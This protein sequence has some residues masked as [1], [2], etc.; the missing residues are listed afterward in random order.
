MSKVYTWE[1]IRNHVRACRSRIQT[2][3]SLR[4]LSTVKDFCFDADHR[5]LYFLGDNQNQQGYTSRD[6]K[7]YEVDLNDVQLEDIKYFYP[8]V[9][10]DVGSS[11]SFTSTADAYIARCASFP[12]A[13]WSP[14]FTQ[15]AISG[16]DPENTSIDPVLPSSKHRI[17]GI[18]RFQLVHDRVLFTFADNIYVAD[19]GQ[20]PVLIPERHP[21]FPSSSSITNSTESQALHLLRKSTKKDPKLGG[22]NNDLVAFIRDRDLWV[23]DFEGHEMQLTF[24]SSNPAM[25]CGLAEYIMQ[26]EFCRSTGYYWGSSTA[27]GFERLLYLETSEEA[28]EQVILKSPLALESETQPVRYPRPGQANAVS[29]LRIVEFRMGSNT[30]QAEIKHKQL[31]N[32][33]IRNMFPWAEYIVRF[34]WLSGGESVWVQILSRDQKQTALVKIRYSYFAS[35]EEYKKRDAPSD[36]QDQPGPEILWQETSDTWINVTDAYY[37]LP[38]ASEDMTKF[39]WASEKSGFRHLYLV[40]KRLECSEA[41]VLQL[42]R[43]DWCVLDKELFVDERRQLVYFMAKKDTCTEAHLYVISFD[44]TCSYRSIHRLTELGFSHQI[45]LNT[46]MDIF[47]DCF[48]SLHH[49][50]VIAIRRLNHDTPDHLPIV[51]EGMTVLLTKIP[52]SSSDQSKSES[53]F[54]PA[55]KFQVAAIPKSLSYDGSEQG[56]GEVQEMT[57]LPQA[58][59]FHYSTSDGVTLYGYLFKP[60]H[61]QAGMT[62]PTVLHVYGGPKSQLVMNDFKYP[63]LLRY[64]LSACFGF[65]VVVIDGRGSWD[66]GMAFESYVKHKLGMVEVQDQLDG[67]RHVHDMKLG[68]E[69]TEDGDVV[70]VVDLSRIAI[71][72]WS[73]GG[74]LSLMGLAQHPDAFRIAIAGAPVTQW[75]LYDSAY[76][77]RYMGLPSENAEAYKRSN[78]LNWV[79][80]FP[81]RYKG[82]CKKTISC[83]TET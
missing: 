47:V 17:P 6:L 32:R 77:E 19:L 12:I 66:R 55:P 72:G 16:Q 35:E 70:S 13:P 34:G 1:Q 81:D 48:S 56:K 52:P 4:T 76:T 8:S 10:E 29:D 50:Q 2:L 22:Q 21:S 67:L 15:C 73:Y 57:R 25:N 3:Y 20:M 43:G 51:A 69:P 78:V 28:V 44:R 59:I 53:T 7:L 65:A 61:Y 54:V 38:Q 40:E 60:V 11:C 36:Y 30:C 33:S 68:A 45:T 46:T 27:T 75:E 64:L 79:G 31:W 41:D 39:I 26:E 24:C 58:T 63:R 83:M 5:K 37:F 23:T 18:S 80:D 74:Y 14:A 62:Y 9:S 82:K 71:T 49:P 42:T